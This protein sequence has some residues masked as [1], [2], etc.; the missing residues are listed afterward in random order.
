MGTIN[1]NEIKEN[2]YIDTEGEQILKLVSYEDVVSSVKGLPGH[3]YQCE[4]SN[5][6]K[7][8]LDF[9][10]TNEIGLIKYKQLLKALKFT[11]TQLQA[12]NIDTLP[13]QILGKKF[14]AFIRR[15]KSKRNS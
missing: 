6:E 14:L 12:I 10:Y 8:K 15:Q 3:R 5:G 1:F 7:I 11:E 4:N 2:T 13:E 9:Y